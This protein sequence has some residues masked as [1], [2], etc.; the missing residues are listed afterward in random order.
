DELGFSGAITA[1]AFGAT[2]TNHRHLAWTGLS[3]FRDE[4]LGEL[5]QQDVSFFLEILFLLKTFFF[6]YLGVSI[7]FSDRRYIWWALAF[8]AAIYLARLIIVRFALSP[9]IATWQ[10][11]SGASL[12]V[13]K[14]L[15]S[16]VLAGIPIAAGIPGAESVRDLTYMVVLVS[17]TLTA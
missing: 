14:G 13:P 9:E 12:M 8:C 17:I 15:V 6:V 10:D 7:Q 3:I 1:L 2:L 4:S 16:A 5:E 11:L